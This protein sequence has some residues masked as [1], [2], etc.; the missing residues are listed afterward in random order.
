VS[1]G[2]GELRRAHEEL[3]AARHLTTGGFS[4]PAVS[5]AYDAAFYAA[6]AALRRLDETRSK[7]SGV[8]AA[9]GQLLVRTGEIDAD[10][11]KLLR[12]LFD[13]RSGAD[14][15]WIA[16]PSP[17][18]AEQAINDADRVVRSVETWLGRSSR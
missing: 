18:E 1:W 13:R 3:A 16:P 14:Y 4:A 9:F 10:A 5:R 17:S 15:D 6:E 11:G 7:H 12:S 2:A 8:I